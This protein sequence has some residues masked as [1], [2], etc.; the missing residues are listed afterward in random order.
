MA[1]SLGAGSASTAASVAIAP[2]SG[3]YVAVQTL[4]GPGGAP[5]PGGGQG[6]VGGSSGS[7]PGGPGATVVTGVVVTAHNTALTVRTARGSRAVRLDAATTVYRVSAAQPGAIPHGSFVSVDAT[8]VGGRQVATDVVASTIT[9][10]FA[11][12]VSGPTTAQ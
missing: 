9:G 3:P 12:I 11:S 7:P 8:A 6:G 1:V 4:G 2:A 5:A 10:A